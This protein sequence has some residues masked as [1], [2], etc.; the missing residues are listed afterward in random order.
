MCAPTSFLQ[1]QK[2]E[3]ESFSES[4]KR[5]LTVSDTQHCLFIERKTLNSDDADAVHSISVS[6]VIFSDGV[7]H[8]FRN[9]AV[10]NNSV[11]DDSQD[12]E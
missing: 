5:D 7:G 8:C 3:A 12:S 2:Y 11:T 4:S 6:V 1:V 10:A 9:I